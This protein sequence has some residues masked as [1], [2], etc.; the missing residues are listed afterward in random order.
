MSEA[1]SPSE[2]L[3]GLDVIFV[4]VASLS[5]VFFL[6]WLA[7]SFQGG[8]RTFE[9]PESLAGLVS[10]MWS[11]LAASAAAV[12]L[13]FLTR[14]HGK[15][16]LVWTLSTSA[17]FLVVVVLI[18]SMLPAAEKAGGTGMDEPIHLDSIPD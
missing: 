8:N 4:L 16:L 15:T 10:G 13:S 2:H 12:V 6:L 9:L 17:G 18:A 1:K 5:I 11:W 3:T 7:T 14:A